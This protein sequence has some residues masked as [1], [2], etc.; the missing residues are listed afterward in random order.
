MPVMIQ[1][2]TI[3]REEAYS[4]IKELIA[5]GA[6]VPNEAVSERSLAEQLGLGRTP[7]REAL[8]G[9]A[10]EGLLDVVPM[11]GTF[12]RQP[13]ID[14]VREIYEVRLAI[15]GMAA[16][17]V[18]E[19]GAPP[20]LLAFGVRLS[21][22]LR[23]KGAGDIEAMHRA[24]WDFHEAII[25]A[26]GNRCML[27]TYETLRLPIMA[28][29]SGRPV[30]AAQARKSLR[31]HLSI[32]DA[33][34]KGNGPLAQARIMD[35]LAGVL[36]ARARLPKIAVLPAKPGIPSPRVRQAA[37]SIETRKGRA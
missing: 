31:E 22:F 12:L 32:L 15:E 4:R 6:L 1:L 19:R 36:E 24:G 17:L 5:D 16:F 10:R 29:R 8:K 23:G 25:A 26:T 7:V 34:E 11:R 18:A 14:D 9:L 21:R 27:Q 35:H 33:I 30:D 13:S 2:A 28:L 3:D 37:K 20:E